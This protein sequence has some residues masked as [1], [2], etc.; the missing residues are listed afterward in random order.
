METIMVMTQRQHHELLQYLVPGDG[1]EAAGALICNQG[2]GTFS[3]RLI[4]TD[5]LHL[6]HR[7]SLRRENHVAWPFAEIFSPETISEIDRQGQSIVT[8]HSHPRSTASRFSEVDD[9]N[10]RALFES[11]FNW[12]DDERLLGSAI[13]LPDGTVMGRTIDISGTFHPMTGTCAVGDDIRMWT[14]RSREPTYAYHS[15]LAQTFGVGTMDLLRGLRVAVV[16]CS[17]TGSILI[18]LLVRNAVGEIVLV[19]DDVVDEKNLN[20][21]TNV[22][23]SDAIKREPKVTALRRA[24]GALGLDTT[25]HTHCGLTD[26]P[27]V[28]AAL[29]D[30]DI[31]FGCVDSAYGRYHLECIASAYLIP[32]FDVGVHLEADGTGGIAA[33]DAVCHYVHPRGTSL[34]SRGVYSMDQVTAENY[35]RTDPAYYREQRVAG[36]LADVGE[37]QP[38]VISLNM[39]AACMAFNDFVARVHRYRLDMNGPFAAQRFRLVHGC[40]ETEEHAGVPHKLFEAHCGAGDRSLLVRNNMA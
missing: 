30:C 21:I 23:M 10:D 17:G 20:R 28:L 4:V 32:Y 40:Y 27:T 26:S 35:Q 25:V 18:E 15:K 13:M 22:G 7:H 33:A 14:R 5:F 36:Y 12:F 37:E 24:V 19:D 3:R 39:Q 38:A 9:I 11:V 16:G 6:P 2:S 34:L 29:V 8:V 31:L 1:L